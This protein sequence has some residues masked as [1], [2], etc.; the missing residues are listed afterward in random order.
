[1]IANKCGNTLY[2]CPQADNIQGKYLSNVAAMLSSTGNQVTQWDIG[3]MKTWA[4]LVLYGKVSKQ[5]LKNCPVYPQ[6][7]GYR[8]R[9]RSKCQILHMRSYNM[10][11]S[12]WTISFHGYKC[13]A[14][15]RT[16]TLWY[17]F[18]QFYRW[19]FDSINW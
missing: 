17:W 2:W 9:H 18:L 11:L 7:Q 15:K 4:K 13:N 10:P 14:F 19:L 6:P 1:M 3:P 8:C 16:Q 12:N 5:H